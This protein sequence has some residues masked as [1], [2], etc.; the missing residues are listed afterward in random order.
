MQKRTKALILLILG[1]IALSTS[2]FILLTT[3]V[4]YN[5][6]DMSSQYGLVTISVDGKQ[7]Y[8]KREA[9]GLNYDS[10]ILSTNKDHCA[11]YNPDSDYDFTNSDPTVYYKVDGE[12]LHITASNAAPPKDFPVKVSIHRITDNS[13]WFDLEENHLEKGLELL[14]IP[15]SDDLTCK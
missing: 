6:P 13:E 8:F 2:I 5:F 7:L 3:L 10:L 14:N 1:V 12:V 11:E 9:R 4:I 15:L